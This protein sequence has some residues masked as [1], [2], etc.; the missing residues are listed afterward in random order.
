MS[1]ADHVQ[2]PGRP[3]L[4]KDLRGANLAF[5][6][7]QANPEH[8]SVED[9]SDGPARPTECVATDLCA[10]SPAPTGLDTAEPNLT[11]HPISTNQ[12]RIGVRRTFKG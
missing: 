4:F 9:L 1:P 3:S 2:R 10:R 12:E 8:A 5:T 11:T 7:E 6:R